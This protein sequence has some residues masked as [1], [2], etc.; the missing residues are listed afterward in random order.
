[1][2]FLIGEPKSATCTRLA[3][4]TGFSHDSANRFLHRENYQPKDMYDESIVDFNPIGGALS[5]DDTVLD[6]PYS[7]S[8]DLVGYFWSGKHHRAVKGIN[9]VTLYHT[10]TSGRHM[11]VNF[12]VCDKSEGKTKNDYFREMLIEVLAWG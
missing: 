1:M 11:P 7:Y 5:V 9:L 8:V 4:V 2:G 3:E 6:K 10:D 12:R